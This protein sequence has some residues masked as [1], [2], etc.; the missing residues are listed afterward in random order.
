MSDTKDLKNLLDR[1]KGEVGPLPVPAEEE[2][3]ATAR[4][5][6]G[7]PAELRREGPAR[8]YRLPEWRAE[9]KQTPSNPAWAENKEAMLFGLLAAL[10][11]SLGGILAG[12]DYLVLIGAV[13]FSLFSLVMCL[14]LFRACFFSRHRV[15]EQQGLAERVDALSRRVELLSARAVAGGAGQRASG[16][17]PDRELEQKVE[18]LRVLV[19]S[20]AKAVE[21]DN[22]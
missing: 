4:P 10:I 12:L 2:F 9:D 16:G 13:V 3:S 14:T 22:K 6:R 18:E 20:L 19:K 11:L 15:P 17:A 8:P 1:L 7:A 5:P 21:G